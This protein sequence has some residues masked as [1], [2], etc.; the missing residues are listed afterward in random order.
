MKAE[1]VDLSYSHRGNKQTET[2]NITTTA[3][4]YN[5]QKDSSTFPLIKNIIKN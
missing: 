2:S 4:N 5:F 3:V 1:V